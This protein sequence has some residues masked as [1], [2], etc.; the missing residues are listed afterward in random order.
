MIDGRALRDFIVTMTAIG[1]IVGV[2]IG[3]AIPVAVD[4]ASRIEIRPAVEAPND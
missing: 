4:F 3:L 2:L 1:V